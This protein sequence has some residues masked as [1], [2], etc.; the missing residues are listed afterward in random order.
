MNLE[1]YKRLWL[2]INFLK[3]ENLSFS[4]LRKLWIVIININLFIYNNERG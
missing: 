2:W 4:F 1:I 3:K